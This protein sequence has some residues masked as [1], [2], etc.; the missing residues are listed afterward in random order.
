MPLTFVYLSCVCNT[1][2]L[3]YSNN[4]FCKIQ[5]VCKWRLLLL[6][7]QSF[8]FCLVL[9]NLLQCSGGRRHSCLAPYLVGKA[10]SPSSFILALAV[11]LP[12]APFIRMW[13]FPSIPRSLKSFLRNE[14]WF[15]KVLSPFWG[16]IY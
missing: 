3:T 4:I 8:I 11:G 10:F 6:L 12:L 15:F 16:C 2:K 7:F 9:L 13:K 5:I 1:A 14:W